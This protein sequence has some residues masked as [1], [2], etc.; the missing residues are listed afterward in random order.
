MNK[1]KSST[2]TNAACVTLR[3]SSTCITS[4]VSTWNSGLK[5]LETEIGRVE[6]GYRSVKIAVID[7]DILVENDVWFAR[8]AYIVENFDVYLSEKNRICL[9]IF[10]CGGWYS[11]ETWGL[12]SY[13][14]MKL[15]A[16]WIVLPRA[17]I[18]PAANSVYNKGLGSIS[19]RFFS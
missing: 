1:H 16:L 15:I 3:V 5:A 9:S 18:T 13:S 11:S 19:Q 12:I 10:G 4:F 14:F 6:R 17:E 7:M 2:I 8:S